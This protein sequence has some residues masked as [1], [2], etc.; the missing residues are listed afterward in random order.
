MKNQK[1]NP[2]CAVGGTA[3]ATTIVWLLTDWVGGLITLV[4][5]GSIMLVSFISLKGHKV[6]K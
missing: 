5:V 1:L 2:G 6:S 3:V 4:V